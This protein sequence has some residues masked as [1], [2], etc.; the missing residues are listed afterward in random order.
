MRVKMKDLDLDVYIKLEEQK[1][2]EEIFEIVNNDE[3][4]L[5]QFIKDLRQQKNT[6]K[7]FSCKY[8]ENKNYQSFL[9]NLKNII[10]RNENILKRIFI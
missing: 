3:S 9:D 10:S 7:K 5:L 2:N 8:I 4:L 6:I 1:D